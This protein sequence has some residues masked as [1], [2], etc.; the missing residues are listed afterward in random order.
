MNGELQ[1]MRL[2][3][4]PSTLM[5]QRFMRAEV[6]TIY[7]AQ[8]AREASGTH[9]V[10]GFARREEALASCEHHRKQGSSMSVFALPAIA[11][12]T[13]NEA[14]VI[15]EEHF[16]SHPLLG[17]N[18]Q[19]FNRLTS[20]SPLWSW[21]IKDTL[22]RLGPDGELWLRKYRPKSHLLLFHATR[23]DKL[24][25]SARSW[26]SIRMYHR[27]TKW[28]ESRRS[29]NMR[30]ITKLAALFSNSLSNDDPGT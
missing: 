1:E 27:P 11:L 4:N 28:S 9:R 2:S 30:A 25:R 17:F 5:S 7:V 10:R 18:T 13:E 6:I 22:A 16:Q 21:T 3:V 19:R 26:V 14:A 8:E 24:D 23:A 29:K 15:L 12:Q 20:R